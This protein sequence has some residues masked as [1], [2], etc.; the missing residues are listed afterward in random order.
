MLSLPKLGFVGSREMSK[1][2]PRIIH[3]LI[4]ELK[5]NFVIV[6]GLARGVDTSSHVAAVKQKL[7]P[8][9]SLVMG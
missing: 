1:E 7:Q 8:L 2:A 3:K 5:Q 6:S 9:L 4:E